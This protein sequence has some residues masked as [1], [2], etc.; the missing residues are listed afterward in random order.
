MPDKQII[1][2]ICDRPPQIS[3]EV[4]IFYFE[5]QG[6]IHRKVVY[7]DEIEILMDL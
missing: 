1:T 7:S 4:G 5:I 6:K 3:R 2:H